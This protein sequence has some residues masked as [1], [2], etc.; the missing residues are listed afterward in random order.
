[1]LLLFVLKQKGAKNSRKYK[2]VRLFVATFALRGAQYFQRSN[3]V[4]NNLQFIQ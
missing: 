3:Q 1:M 4:Q 2:A